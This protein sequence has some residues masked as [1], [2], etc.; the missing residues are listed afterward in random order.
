MAILF[1][2]VG[3]SSGYLRGTKYF[4]SCVISVAAMME[5]VFDE[6]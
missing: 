2:I 4:E 1:R 6:I 3:V 5:T